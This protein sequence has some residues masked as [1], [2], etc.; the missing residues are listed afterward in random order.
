[1]KKK[2]KNIKVE[3]PEIFYGLVGAVGTNMDLVCNSLIESLTELN[4]TC[5]II[6]LSSLLKIIKKKNWKPLP[7]APEDIRIHK[8]MDRGNLFR[9]T[10][11]QGDALALLS[12][13]AIRKI[14]KDI[15]GNP[16]NPVS[17]QA[18]ILRSLK[19]PKEVDTLRKIYGTNFILIAAYS[20]RETRLQELSKK[21]GESYHAFRHNDYRP[22][23]DKIILRDE[24]EV[25]NPYGQNVRETFPLADVFLDTSDFDGLKNSLNRFQ[26]LLFNS[27]YHTPTRDEY[28]MFHAKAAALRSSSLS[29]QVGAV[30]STPDGDII[31]VGTNE[32]PKAGGGLYWCGDI[33][34]KRD[35]KM[36]YDTSETMKKDLLAEVLDRLKKAKWLAPDKSKKDISELVEESLRSGRLPPMKGAQIMNIIEFGRAVHA[37]MASLCD[38]AC[39]GV[40]VKG[41]NLYT[42]TFPCHGCARHIVA[43]GIK[44]VIYIEPYP[45]SLVPEL[46]LDSIALNGPHQNNRSVIFKPFVG[47]SPRLYIDLFSDK[48]KSSNKKEGELLQD[49]TLEK[50]KIMGYSAIYLPSEE[51][52]FKDLHDKLKKHKIE[53]YE[54]E[55]T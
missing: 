49:K 16:L 44:N 22:K 24:A 13:G 42:T 20:P 26:E 31:A 40:P 55:G 34:D 36:G 9:M 27:P 5:K 3:G 48:M 28:M 4:Y 45:K 8:H 46:Y 10:L 50:P 41:C 14:R 38:A 17:R 18:Y 1:M 51:F 25:D 15:S 21:I 43:S 30:I 35:F 52:L 23:A 47:I 54:K 37:E 6:R 19:H 7:D 39:R 12:I 53:L 33:P 11:K 32:V 29:R 2:E